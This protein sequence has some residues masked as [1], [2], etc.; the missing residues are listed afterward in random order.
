MSMSYFFFRL[1][2]YGVPLYAGMSALSTVERLTG[3]LYALILKA[4]FDTITGKADV[5]LSVY[6]LLA[7]WTAMNWIGMIGFWTIGRV[8]REFLTGLL[9]GLLQR[10]LLETLLS[11]RPSRRGTSSGDMLNRFRDDV[12]ASVEPTI[13]IAELIGL[14]VSFGIA[15][16]IM[17]RINP[18]ITLVAF[19]PGVVLYGVT[20]LL[21]GRIE[22]YRLRSREATSRVSNSLG[23][24]LN[25][26]QVLQVANAE[27][28][29]VGQFQ[30]LSSDRRRADLKEAVIDALISFLNSSLAV[31]GTGVILLVA[32]QFMRA[33]S[34]TVGD[35]VLFIFLAGGTDVA[36]MFR[37]L[38]EFMAANRRARVSVG[39]LADLI[40]ESAPRTIVRGGRLHLR[41]AIPEESYPRKA[42]E[43][44]LESLD[45]D[46]LTY[47]YPETGRGIN[48]VSLRISRGSFIV[49]T[50]RVG[51][52]KTTLVKV[53][54]G[55]LAADSGEVKWNKDKVGDTRTFL[56]PPR[57][58]YT[59]QA[60][61]LFS[62]TVRNN[63]LM[64]L[65]ADQDRLTAAVRLGVME[66]DLDELEN[67]IETIIGPRGVKL[68]GGQIQRTAAAR[69][70]VRDPEL[71]VFDDL[72]SALDVETEQMLWERVFELED[73]TSL[74]VSHRRA[75]YRRAN[76][77]LVLQDGLVEAEGSLDDLLK[78]SYEMQRLWRGDVGQKEQVEE[79]PP[80][81]NS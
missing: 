7:I 27:E 36:S 44:R 35:F 39:R 61:W 40:H 23:E 67:G 38:T 11:S 70:F 30:E 2:R 58:A 18:W 72:S 53:L 60:P 19:L 45:L 21:T 15:V 64:G 32:A 62:D 33:G 13:M 56:V 81:L 31:I 57:C 47:T 41:A 66:L 49:V 65:E 4:V 12:E 46:G 68:S 79:V 17:V 26:V 6:T 76:H 34:F 73:V 5:G 14:V 37:W 25:A 1:I 16:L 50:G 69:M 28:R 51:S 78:T 52:G 43:H 29:A 59:P 80:N 75:A 48:G 54:L 63:I 3:I 22:A 74:V 8:G 9:Q 20:R 77:I 55:L 42:E 71:L 10:N 24:F